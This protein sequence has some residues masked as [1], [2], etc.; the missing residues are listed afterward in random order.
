MTQVVTI[1]PTTQSPTREWNSG[2]FACFNDIQSCLCGLFCPMCLLCD[3][4]GRMGEG[5]AYA[6]CCCEVA[7]LTLRAK[8]RAEQ[9]IQGSLCND[10]VVVT[11][12]GTCVLCQM[13]R[14]LKS[15][16]K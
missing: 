13:D 5:C 7:P 1:Q 12:C 9:R 10:A 16:G 14:E 6:S 11:F 15:I 8:L 3:I 2:L 4:S